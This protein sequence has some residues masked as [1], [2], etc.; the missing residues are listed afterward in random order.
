MR[1]RQVTA[2][3]LAR[4][5]SSYLSEVR[6]GSVVLEVRRGK[7]HVAQV[8]PPASAAGGFPIEQ[9]NALVRS[10]PALEPDDAARFARDLEE[11]DHTVGAARDP[12]AL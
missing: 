12:W 5:L 9:L 8:V 10:L 6:Y 2:T 7:E 3:E 4:N 11:L 1:I